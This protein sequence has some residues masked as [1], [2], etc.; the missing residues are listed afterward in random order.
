MSKDGRLQ[1]PKLGL[2]DYMLRDF[3]REKDRDIV[4][5]PVG[6]NYDRTLEDRSLLR[7][8]D[9]EANRRNGWFVFW[10]TTRFIGHSL[11]LMVSVAGAGMVMPV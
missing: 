3:N 10:T 8:L 11:V 9:R 6:I 7:A 1:P 2:V 4:F 5:I